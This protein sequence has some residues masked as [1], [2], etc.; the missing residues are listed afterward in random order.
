MERIKYM[1]AAAARPCVL[2]VDDHADTLNLLTRILR[3]EGYR[4]VSASGYAEALEMAGKCVFEVLVA[5]IQLHDGS[6]WE[7]LEELKGTR[8]GLPAVAMTGH[9]M[10]EDLERSKAAGYCVHLTKPIEVERLILAIEHCLS[11]AATE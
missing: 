5:D 8:P 2:L 4:V 9:G 1:D 7:L 10:E 6:G 11:F 3:M